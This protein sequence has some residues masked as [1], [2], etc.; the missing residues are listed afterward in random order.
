MANGVSESRHS[1][2]SKGLRRAFRRT[3]N[4][5]K[6]LRRHR[7]SVGKARRIA[8]GTDLKLHLGCGQVLRPGW[9]N[10]DLFARGADVHLDLREEWP[11]RSNTVLHVYSEHVMEHFDF[12]DEVNHFLGESLRVLKPGGI[13]DVGVPDAAWSL[14]A[15]G[16]ENN[17]CWRISRELWHPA[18]CE[19]PLDHINF[20][21]RQGGEHKYAWDEKTLTNQF[22]KS[23]FTSIE[24]R[25]FDPALDTESRKIGTLYLR[26][27]KPA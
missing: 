6:L 4:E 7:R 16:D 15:Y 9:V 12:P 13:I 25:D 10:I 27:R 22:R 2:L 23:G 19:T 21:F 17:E 20:L 1:F 14:N 3:W 5:L 11:F 26:A 8:A 24:R 18:Y